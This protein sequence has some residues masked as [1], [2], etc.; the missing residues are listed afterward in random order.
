MK[1]E[2]DLKNK[3]KADGVWDLIKFVILAIIIVMPIRMFIAQP[4]VVSGES[5]FPTFKDKEYLIIDEI[6]YLTGEP[7]RGDVIV[8][9]YPNDTKRF[10]IK[11]VI[12]LPNETIV[13]DNGKIKIINDLNPEGF[14]LEE[15]YI[16]EVFDTTSA[17]QTGEKEFFVLGDNRNK[18]SDSRFW[19]ILP[20]KLIVGRAYL[21]LLPIKNISYLPGSIESEK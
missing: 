10:F 6:S 20:R 19:G 1:N 14:L 11:R 5:M 2:I 16:N 13:I 21:R 17:Y 9:R 15:P 7:R 3:K 12:G 4:F 18:S 8:F